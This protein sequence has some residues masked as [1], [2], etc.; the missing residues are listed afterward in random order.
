MPQPP[1]TSRPI[2]QARPRKASRA[3]SPATPKK[4]A[5]APRSKRARMRSSSSTYTPEHQATETLTAPAFEDL[6]PPVYSLLLYPECSPIQIED[7]LP[8]D[9]PAPKLLRVEYADAVPIRPTPTTCLPPFKTS[10]STLEV[11]VP[12]AMSFVPVGELGSACG[13]SRLY[14]SSSPSSS[15][16][17]SGVACLPGSVPCDWLIQAG[18][19][20]SSL[21]GTTAAVA[22]GQME[23]DDILMG[24]LDESG[25]EDE[26]VLAWLGI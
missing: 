5:G 14:P 9:A 3:T 6:E 8:E 7:E 1:S 15:S 12:S 11:G 26:D 24:G 21:A 18:G 22:V 16:S 23:F 25:A 13:T 10:P 2:P 17:G 20:L 4:A 19:T